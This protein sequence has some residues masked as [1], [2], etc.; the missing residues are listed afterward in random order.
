MEGNAE[1]IEIIAREIARSGPVSFCWFMEQA[2]YHPIHGY[3]ASGKARIGREGDFITNVSVGPLFGRLLASQF[4][5]MWE[6][7]VRPDSF[8]IV[9][10]GANNG[11]FAADVLKELRETELFPALQYRIVEPVPALRAK[12]EIKLA[13]MECVEWRGSLDALDPFCGVH[14]SNELL[15]AMPVHLLRSADGLWKERFVDIQDGQFVFVDVPA[16]LPELPPVRADGYQT[17]INREAL[18]WVD[19]IA[20]KITHGFIL[21]I[22]YGYPREDFFSPD[23]SAGTLTCYHAHRR[24]ADPLANVGY[25]DI[26]AHVEFSSLIE[27]AIAQRMSLCGFTDQHRY[28]VGLA[29][30]HLSAMESDPKALRAFRTLMH[31]AFMGSAF[32]VL[33]LQKGTAASLRGF[34]GR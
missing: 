25:T 22:D 31:P 24:S 3:Y 26:T 17:E 13:G 12:Q 18:Q 4:L 32:K 16:T 1:L 21:A 7:L 33:A 6:Q 34:G 20:S 30:P 5:E 19:Q 8:T 27:Q 23:R 15:D 11:D 29:A 28:L 14:F 10:Q 9:E 2:L